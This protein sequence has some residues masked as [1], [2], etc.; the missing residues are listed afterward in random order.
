M[1]PDQLITFSHVAEHL[2]IS[3]AALALHLTQPAVSGQLQALQT[4]FGEPLY[5]RQGRGIA[6]TAAGQRLALI[7]NQLRDTLDEARA[8]RHAA[9]SLQTGVLRIGASTTPASYLLPELVAEFRRRYPGITIELVAGNTQD[10]LERLTELDLAVI[11]GEIQA[12]KLIR[13]QIFPW[14]QDE[15][16]AI[17]RQDHVL[18]TRQSVSLQALAKHSLV[19]RE[20]GSGVRQMIV[21]AFEAQGLPVTGHLELA[22]VEGVKQGV[23]AGLGIG[24]VSELSMNHEDGSLKAL[25][26]GAGLSRTMHVLLPKA[27]RRSPS[28]EV[29]IQRMAL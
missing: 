9:V 16:V 10:I 12:S 11:E 19:M 6:L 24:F 26:I 4:A 17:C 13:H 15:V 22:G 7:A 25:R 3:H 28:A 5:Q 1:T 27:S 21:S 23:R 29:F 18:A 2:N 14:H 8:L 20:R